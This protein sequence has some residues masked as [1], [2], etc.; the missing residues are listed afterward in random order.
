MT[1][2]STKSRDKLRSNQFAYV[3]KHGGEHLPIHDEEHIRNA[4]A[5]FNQTDFE[6]ATAKQSARRKI[7]AA[8]RRHGIEV[9]E[10]SNIAK[11]PRR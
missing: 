6:S 1:E 7:L 10:D 2:L 3:D 4:M 5:R 8:A 11:P 9:S